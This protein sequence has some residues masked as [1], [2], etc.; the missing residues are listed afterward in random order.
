MSRL[1]RDFLFLQVFEEKASIRV[2]DAFSF[3]F[4]TSRQADKLLPFF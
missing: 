1:C 2:T 3:L 4:C